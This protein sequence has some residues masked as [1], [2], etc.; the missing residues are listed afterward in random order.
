MYS[1]YCLRSYN[2]L[3]KLV[4]NH[5]HKHGNIICLNYQ[6]SEKQCFHLPETYTAAILD[7]TKRLL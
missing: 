6:Q 1:I 5:M 3:I 4:T 2:E 7:F